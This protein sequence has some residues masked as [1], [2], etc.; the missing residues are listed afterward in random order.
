LL[1]IGNCTDDGKITI[2]FLVIAT[3]QGCNPENVTLYDDPLI[4]ANHHDKEQRV[5]QRLACASQV[6]HG[7]SCDSA[8]FIDLGILGVDF[9]IEV[10]F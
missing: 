5:L 7:D 1:A 6:Y 2:S 10:Y 8:R 3:C 4:L 9:D